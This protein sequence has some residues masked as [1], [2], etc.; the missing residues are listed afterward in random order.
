MRI[1]IESL[2]EDIRK[3]YDYDN[4]EKTYNAYQNKVID[5]ERS[6]KEI[7]NSIIND[8][9]L[10]LTPGIHL[11]E[12]RREVE[13]YIRENHPIIISI[14]FVSDQ[15]TTDYAFFSNKNRY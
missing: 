11:E 9:V 1:I 12:Q 3:K 5:D 10:I 4:L 13:D 15:Y 6:F 2:S 7:V 14:N 8:N